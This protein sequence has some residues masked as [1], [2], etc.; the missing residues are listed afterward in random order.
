MTVEALDRMTPAWWVSAEGSFLGIAGPDSLRS[1]SAIL[2]AM[3]G[4]DP[5]DPS[6][7]ASLLALLESPVLRTLALSRPREL[8]SLWVEDWLGI[9]FAASPTFEREGVATFR[10]SSQLPT[11]ETWRVESLLAGTPRA[12][13]QVTR[14]YEVVTD[15]QA[16][17]T[18]FERSGEVQALLRP[19]SRRPASVGERSAAAWTGEDGQ[20]REEFE[21]TLYTFSWP[22]EFDAPR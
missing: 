17:P 18:D 1:P 7:R 6:T 9:D 3:Q 8:W 11:R 10:G 21:Q 16:L 15:D 4:D 19:H 14:I 20:P 13:L 5:L 22:A 2:Q 12:R